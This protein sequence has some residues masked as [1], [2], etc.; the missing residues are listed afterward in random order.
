MPDHPA[1]TKPSRFVA[2][3]PAVQRG[4]DF[5]TPSAGGLTGTIGVQGVVRQ[6]P[7]PLPSNAIGAS[8]ATQN[9]SGKADVSVV[10]DDFRHGGLA[11]VLLHQLTEP[12]GTDVSEVINTGNKVEPAVTLGTNRPKAEGTQ[13]LLRRPQPVAAHK[14]DGARPARAEDPPALCRVAWAT[15]ETRCVANLSSQ[16]RRSPLGQPHRERFDEFAVTTASQD[17]VKP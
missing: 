14:A 10:I 13:P 12:D 17:A 9:T 7:N 2:P 6:S 5:D 16:C 11:Q 4:W 1:S 15:F 3:N 8:V